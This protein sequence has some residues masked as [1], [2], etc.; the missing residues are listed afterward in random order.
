[1]HICLKHILMGWARFKHVS[2]INGLVGLCV[3]MSKINT[4]KWGQV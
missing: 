4:D 3:N 1:M 2:S